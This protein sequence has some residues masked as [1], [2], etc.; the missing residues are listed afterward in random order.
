[1]EDNKI[2][3]LYWQRSEAAI[4]ETE[5][6]YGAYCH[7]IARNILQ[8]REDAE[9]CV[10]DTWLK[11]WNSM[12]E[13]RPGCLMAFLGKIV[14]NLS[15]D[16]Y[17][18]GHA[19]KRGEGET[20]LVLTELEDCLSASGSAEQAVEEQLLT[21][22]IDRFLGELTRQKRVLFVRRYWYLDPVSEI[23]QSCGQSEN[24]VTLTLFRLRRKLRVYL[25]KEGFQL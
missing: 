7:S 3:D 22:C 14:R 16:R 8:S 25:E 17:R 23:A 6:K 10:N 13:Q 15:L 24:A 2:I 12:P 20:A 9:E 18:K 4:A 1:M 21:E 11:A 19:Q 5:G